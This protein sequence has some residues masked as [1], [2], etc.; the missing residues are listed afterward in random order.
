MWAAGETIP[1]GAWRLGAERSHIRFST[2]GDP[3]DIFCTMA[4][5]K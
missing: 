2:A 5:S 3:S 1:F 4:R